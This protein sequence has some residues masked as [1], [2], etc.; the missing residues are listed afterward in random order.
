M[1]EYASEPDLVG[2]RSLRCTSCGLKS[3]PTFSPPE[4][5][6]HKCTSPCASVGEFLRTELCTTCAG[7]VQI[8]LFACDVHGECT[9]RTQI[10]AIAVC[11]GC[12]QYVASEP[13][14]Q[15]AE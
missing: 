15:P 5:F 8:K 1:I 11:H 3:A 7:K 10:G 4:R 9:A 13:S 2:R 12:K 6:F 14:T